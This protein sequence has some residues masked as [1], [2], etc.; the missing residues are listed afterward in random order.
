MS[1]PSH[2]DQSAAVSAEE[3]ERRLVEERAQAALK[4][5][6]KQ[7][8]QAMA[9]KRQR[10]LAYLKVNRIAKLPVPNT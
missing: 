9:I 10:N 2:A 1:R 4:L 7:R 6:R 5:Q 8:L 3:R